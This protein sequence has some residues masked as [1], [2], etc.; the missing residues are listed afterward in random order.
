MRY[1]RSGDA[2]TSD[3]EGFLLPIQNACRPS[4][5][6]HVCMLVI[7]SGN[8]VSVHS[9]KQDLFGGCNI[10]PPNKLIDTGN[11][12]KRSTELYTQFADKLHT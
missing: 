5:G 3:M 10:V 9:P 12:P 11:A 7:T 2:H 4:Y 6:N 1:A 8:Q